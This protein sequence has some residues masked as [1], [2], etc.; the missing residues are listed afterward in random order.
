MDISRYIFSEDHFFSVGL[1]ELLTTQFIDDSF[2]IIDIDSLCVDFKLTIDD[3]NRKIVVFIKDDF[4]YY[5]LYHV[6]GITFIDKRG[7]VSDIMH[8][9]VSNDSKY[10]YR[11]KNKLSAREEETFQYILEG[12]HPIEISKRLGV[13][14][15][16]FYSYRKM[17][18]NKL[19]V[20]NRI[21]LYKSLFRTEIKSLES[22]ACV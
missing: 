1:S 4:E 17:I 3:L 14:R 7:R 19:R 21:C 8:C 11:V 2:C 16:T 22:L 10:H 12:L 20:G 6:H 18:M 5:T 13:K 15:K 9:F